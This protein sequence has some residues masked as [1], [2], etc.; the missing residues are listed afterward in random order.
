AAAGRNGA[1]RSAAGGRT[2]T[3][4]KATG[5]RAAARKATTREAVD[6][7]QPS[8]RGRRAAKAAKATAT[9]SDRQTRAYRRMPD[10]I[11]TVFRQAGGVTRTA[12]HYG[13]PRHT[14][15]G[16]IRRLRMQGDLPS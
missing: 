6:E 7:R 16:W 14:A 12:E 9:K 8:T 4:R 10:D 1:G 11:V 2:A 15:Q 13:V 3:G 5:R